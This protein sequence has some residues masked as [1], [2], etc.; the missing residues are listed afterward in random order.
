MSDRFTISAPS[1]LLPFL[2]ENLSGWTRSR[3]KERLRTGC[4]TV[5]DEVVTQHNHPLE[6]GDRVEVLPSTAAPHISAPGGLWILHNGGELVAINKPHG[7]LSVTAVEGDRN[8]LGILREQLSRPGK[9]AKIW[10]VHRLDRDTSGVLVFATTQP[11]Q[12]LVMRSWDEAEKTYLAI[13]EGELTRE[14]GTIDQPLRMD[15]NGFRTR[16]G[17]QPGAKEAVTHYKVQKIRNG[18]TLLE[19]KIDTGRT[20]QIR[21]HL[22][23]LGHPVVGDDRYGTKGRR[24]GLHAMHLTFP[25]PRGNGMMS[26]E[27]RPPRD[28]MA[29][30]G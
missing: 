24:M 26:F 14:E 29:L 8:A 23:W 22:A 9:D 30:I 17:R 2:L 20:H 21:A 1:T 4:V 11:T 28:F 18:R 27:A 19:V 15:S 16:V 5:N 12:Q 7:L 25:N 13:V 6:D 10:P 3:T